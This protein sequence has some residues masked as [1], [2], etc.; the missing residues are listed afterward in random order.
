MHEI[1]QIE[2]LKLSNIPGNIYSTQD[3]DVHNAIIVL[4]VVANSPLHLQNERT[5]GILVRL[6][7]SKV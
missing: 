3:S 5:H 7:S 1:S 2:T 4:P 6:P